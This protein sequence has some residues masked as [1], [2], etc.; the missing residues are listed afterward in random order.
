LKD[1]FPLANVATLWLIYGV[2]L[3]IPVLILPLLTRVVSGS[4]FGLYLYTLSFS[5]WFTVFIEYGFTLSSTR[6]IAVAH[7]IDE[8]RSI[9][10]R[11]QAARALLV[12]LSLAVFLPSFLVI[13]IVQRNPTWAV[14]AWL[15]AI[16]SGYSPVYYFQGRERLKIVGVVEV[17]AGITTLVFVVLVVKG[18]EN[19][20]IFPAFLVVV[21]FLVCAT[22]VWKTWQELRPLR[23]V[24]FRF[25]AGWEYLRAGFGI[26]L[27]QAAV[28]LYTTFNVVFLGFFCS[29]AE[30]GS[31]AGGERLVR[32]GL[33]FYGQVSTALFPRINSLGV[34]DPIGMRKLRRKA[35]LV[36]G[37]LGIAGC[38]VV[39]VASDWVGRSF[40]SNKLVQLHSILICMAFVIPAI[41][42]S[43]VLGF[44]Y[45]LVDRLESIFNRVIVIAGV[46]N[47]VISFFLIKLLGP[48]GMAVSWL[49]IEWSVTFALAAIILWKGRRAHV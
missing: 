39:L 11:T 43:N 46:S 1:K 35:L 29:P 20:F 2:R 45:M 3:V 14:V 38:L 28:S 34:S 23:V 15:M 5:S 27:F 41:A 30:V 22:L 12:I 25:R 21:R 17:V 18:D 37:A 24:S 13:E 10:E 32:A 44:Q 42:I 36:M 33:G 48:L 6:E 26:F 4:S 19:F 16:F 31:Y 8:I 49:I 40:F 47:L 7:N 9:V